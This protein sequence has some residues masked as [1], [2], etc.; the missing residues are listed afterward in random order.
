MQRLFESE[1]V[2]AFNFVITSPNPP[3]A[4]GEFEEVLIVFTC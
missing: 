2:N 1:Q 3:N 4:T